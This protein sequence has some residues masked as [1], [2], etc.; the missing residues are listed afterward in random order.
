LKFIGLT[1]EDRSRLKALLT[2]IRPNT[3]HSAPRSPSGSELSDA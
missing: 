1:E 3:T 2:R